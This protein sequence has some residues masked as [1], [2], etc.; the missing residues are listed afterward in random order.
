MPRLGWSVRGIAALAAL[1]FL[2]GCDPPASSTGS[3]GVQAGF[4]A[5]PSPSAPVQPA[6]GGTVT[7]MA[8]GDLRFAMTLPPGWSWSPADSRA[9][10][11]VPFG[12][13]FF[14]ITASDLP[15]NSLSAEATARRRLDEMVEE[16]L[17][18]RISESAS[19]TLR[20]E[21]LVAVGDLNAI[22]RVVSTQDEARA[23]PVMLRTICYLRCAG[24]EITIEGF[25]NNFRESRTA[26]DFYQAQAELLRISQSFRVQY[27]WGSGTG[28]PV[29][30]F[31][32]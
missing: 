14:Q 31:A 15:V 24:K 2:C 7:E 27:A 4:S 9:V 11:D 19:T 3:S 18:V 32:E 13:N 8:V 21:R 25:Y 26:S 1:L 29:R 5:P 6:I 16:E 12:S 10:K 20:E 30:R 22:W 23:Q 17:P 28:S